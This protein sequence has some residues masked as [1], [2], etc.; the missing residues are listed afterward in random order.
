VGEEKWRKL[1]L[2]KIIKIHFFLP[3][4]ESK[5]LQDNLFLAVKKSKFKKTLRKKNLSVNQKKNQKWED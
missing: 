5:C 2:K 4:Q 1:D 3:A